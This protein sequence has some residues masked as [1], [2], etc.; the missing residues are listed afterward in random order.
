MR[1]A[2][3]SG[4]GKVLLHFQNIAFLLH[5]HVAEGSEGV[6]S[7]GKREGMSRQPCENSSRALIPF[8]KGSLPGLI[9]HP[10]DPLLN[11]TTL[12]LK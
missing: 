10:E 1:A 9:I 2:S 5:V 7:P 4:F 11:T 3:R 8:V 6:L 12:G